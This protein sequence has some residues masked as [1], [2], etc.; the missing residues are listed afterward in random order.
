[1]FAKPAVATL[2]HLLVGSG[3]ALPR[4]ARFAGM[5]A[6]F[7]VAPFSFCCTIGP[8]GLL[9][10][11]SSDAAADVVCV[12]PPSLLPRLALQ[13]EAAS[14]QI[15]TSGDA[16]L[17]AELLYLTRNLRWDAAEDL[18]RVTG[19][20]AAERIVRLVSAKHRQAHETVLNLSQALAEYW[21]EESPL[22][23][24]PTQVAAFVQQVDQL[25]DDVARLEQRLARLV[26]SPGAN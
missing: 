11:A 25:R 26:S 22:L 12:V 23:A 24:K 3:W 17:L 9:S 5:T 15:E 7:H 16:A 20:I 6:R 8:D 13:D 21:T 4:L 14:N 18:S 10:A 1:M 2:N 19:D